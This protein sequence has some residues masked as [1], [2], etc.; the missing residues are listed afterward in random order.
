MGIL[1]ADAD[2]VCSVVYQTLASAEILDLVLGSASVDYLLAR[3]SPSVKV[4]WV[5]WTSEI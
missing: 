3:L 2:E 4:G 1:V 5:I